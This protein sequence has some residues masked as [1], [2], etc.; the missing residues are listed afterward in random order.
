MKNRTNEKRQ[1]HLFAAFR[2]WKQQTSVGFLKTEN[3]RKFVFLSLQTIDG[4]CCSL[5]Q[6]RCPSM[7]GC[8]LGQNIKEYIPFPQLLYNSD[9]LY[10]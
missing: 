1:L 2:K 10:P 3:G 8:N 5:F 4:Y 9:S 6:Q 7:E